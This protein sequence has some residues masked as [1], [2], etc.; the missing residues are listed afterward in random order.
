MLGKLIKNQFKANASAVYNIYIAMGIIGVIMLILL[1]VDWT[2]WGDMGV[3]IGLAVKCLASFALC[4]AAFIGV[5][6]TLTAVFGEYSRTMFKNEG[7]LT[8]TLPV[9]SSSLLFSK[10]LVGSFWVVLSYVVF[11]LC[12]FGSTIY[13]IRHS[14]A[15]VEG[16]DMAFTMYEMLTALVQE[17]GDAF[18]IVAPSV[19]VVLNLAS[20]AAFV[21]GV[22][23]CVFVLTVMFG[24]TLAHCRPFSKLGP[25]LGALLYF[26]G[27]AFAI[28]F[29][30][31]LIEKIIK[32]YIFVSEDAYTF[33]VDPAQVSLAWS[34]GYAG[35][36]I[37]FVYCSA[38][39]AVVLFLLTAVLIDRKVNVE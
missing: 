4:L 29:I 10:W 27:S 32:V 13:L 5:I 22:F 37:T 30:S 3:G 38:V 16:D 6:S 8:M 11:C 31:G 17:A 39:L 25:R 24:I 35:M 1:L 19:T 15:L 18:G 34:N 23:V 7:L 20:I 21:G 28:C 2:K 26:F 36:P 9:R 33:V 12:G 14:M